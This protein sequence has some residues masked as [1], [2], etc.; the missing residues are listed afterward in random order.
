MAR[1]NFGLPYG[2]RTPGRDEIEEPFKR[3]VKKKLPLF[4]LLLLSNFVELRFVPIF[5]LSRAKF[6]MP[7]IIAFP[8][9]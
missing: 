2:L 8:R 4:E 9:S 5:L 7:V 3:D 6:C 1:L